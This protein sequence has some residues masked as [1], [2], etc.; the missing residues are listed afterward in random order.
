MKV[1]ALLTLKL[2]NVAFMRL[3]CQWKQVPP[4][5]AIS[6]IAGGWKRSGERLLLSP[7][8]LHA[9]MQKRCTLTWR[10]GLNRRLRDDDRIWRYCWRW[11]RL[12]RVLAAAVETHLTGSAGRTRTGSGWVCDKQKTKKT[13]CCHTV[14]IWTF[15]E[16][17]FHRLILFRRQRPFR[18][19]NCWQSMITRFWCMAGDHVWNSLLAYFNSSPAL[20]IFRARLKTDLFSISFTGVVVHCYWLSFS[21]QSV[22]HL[23]PLSHIVYSPEFF[24]DVFFKLGLLE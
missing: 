19:I 21:C 12:A 22:K 5:Q 8:R 3:Q 14:G 16:L 9:S 6:G 18:T 2:L 1:I 23:H 4:M 13:G 11:H 10:R 17:L 20:S 15:C 7:A 24:I